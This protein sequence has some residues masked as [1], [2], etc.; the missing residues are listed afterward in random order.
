MK[1]AV[2]GYS[3]SGKST[4][5]DILGE[6]YTIPVL[7]LDKVNFLPGW[8]EKDTEAS[9]KIVFE[10]MQKPSWIIDGNYAKLYQNERLEEA[11]KIIF[12]SFNRFSCLFRAYGRYRKN[13]GKVRSSMADGCEEKFDFEFIKWILHDGR[14]RDKKAKHKDILRRYDHKT[15][16]IKNQKQLDAFIKNS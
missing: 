9:R 10:F 1:I 7:H 15:V 13:K 5:A 14:T 8:V 4:L 3:G 12:L 16:V 6:K 11:D 2:I